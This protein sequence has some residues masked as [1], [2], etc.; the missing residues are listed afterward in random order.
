MIIG[1]S[2]KAQAGKDTVCRMIVYTI[3]YYTHSQR[4][5]PFGIDHYKKCM[6]NYNT[7]LYNIVYPHTCNTCF[8]SR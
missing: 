1:I 2:G 5:M 3:W 7:L 6:V 8:V 4:L